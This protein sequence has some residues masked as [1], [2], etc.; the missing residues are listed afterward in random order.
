M[1]LLFIKMKFTPLISFFQIKCFLSRTYQKNSQALNKLVMIF[2]KVNTSMD[3]PPRSRSR[4]LPRPESSLHLSTR[5]LPSCSLK[6]P[7]SCLVTLQVNFASFQTSY[8]WNQTVCILLQLAS[9][10]LP[11]ICE[12]SMSRLVHKAMK[13]DE[14]T[15]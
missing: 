15:K 8:K 4:T 13:L 2:Y 14:L 7:F 1:F 5:L 3:S 12:S 11:Y 9:F 10:I 6:G